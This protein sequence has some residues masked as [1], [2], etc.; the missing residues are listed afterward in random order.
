VPDGAMPV[1]FSEESSIDFIAPQVRYRRS[2]AACQQATGRE[3]FRTSRAA[4]SP[5]GCRNPNRAGSSRRSYS[6]P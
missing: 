4:R 1:G 6:R 5:S 2:A 3:S